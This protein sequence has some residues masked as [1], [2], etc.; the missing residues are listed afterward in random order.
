MTIPTQ[1]RRMLAEDGRNL[2]GEYR[3]LAPARAPIPIQR[4]TIRRLALVAGL[5][6]GAAL[7]VAVTV[8]NLESAGF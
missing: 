3:S 7:G 8:L 2:V 5:A 4:W 1:L 6:A